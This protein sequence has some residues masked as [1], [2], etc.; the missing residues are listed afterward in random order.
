MPTIILLTTLL[1]K[2]TFET[3]GNALARNREMT[4]D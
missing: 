2:Q 4:T 3:G 1:L